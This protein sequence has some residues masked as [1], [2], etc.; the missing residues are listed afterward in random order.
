VS[1]GQVVA[2]TVRE[3]YERQTRPFYL[4]FIERQRLQEDAEAARARQATKQGKIGTAD[5]L[6]RYRGK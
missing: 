5:Y 6:I 4:N 2:D 1:E 3:A